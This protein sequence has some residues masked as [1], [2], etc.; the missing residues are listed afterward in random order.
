MSNTP[1]ISSTRTH[2]TSTNANTAPTGRN[3]V[4][5]GEPPPRQGSPASRRTNQRLVRSIEDWQRTGRADISL[6]RYQQSSLVHSLKKWEHPWELDR[7]YGKLIMEQIERLQKSKKVRP[8][9]V[10]IN[11]LYAN[12]KDVT[13]V[14]DKFLQAKAKQDK[15]DD[16][17][18]HKDLYE[19]IY[20]NAALCE[21]LSDAS[22]EILTLVDS[23]CR[24]TLTF[25]EAERAR[26]ALSG[27]VLLDFLRAVKDDN[28]LHF[29]VLNRK[30]YLVPCSP[31]DLLVPIVLKWIPDFV[32][33]CRTIALDEQIYAWNAG[34]MPV[35][36]TSRE[37]IKAAHSLCKNAVKYALSVVVTKVCNGMIGDAVTSFQDLTRQITMNDYFIKQRRTINRSVYSK[38]NQFGDHDAAKLATLLQDIKT[39]IEMSPHYSTVPKKTQAYSAISTLVVALASQVAETRSGDGCRRGT[40]TNF[41]DPPA[42][43]PK[44]LQEPRRVFKPM[45][46]REI[47]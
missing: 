23:T 40:V 47:T 46:T 2:K 45:E 6:I 20:E 18:G 10:I 27:R 43:Q 8:D 14:A 19:P 24:V 36:F 38:L 29:L 42:F 41:D 30:T 32:A 5:F 33:S 21:Q 35:V 4:R 16:E 39:V 7:G 17:V 15:E 13:E 12:V 44:G 28:D 11:K 9:N 1:A 34:P 31:D 26:N 22:S 3:N 25:K 37:D